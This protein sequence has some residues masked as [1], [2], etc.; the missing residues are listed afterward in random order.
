MKENKS[1]KNNITRSEDFSK[2][3][4]RRGDDFRVC[5]QDAEFSRLCIF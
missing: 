4:R 5:L 2:P 3:M 1:N